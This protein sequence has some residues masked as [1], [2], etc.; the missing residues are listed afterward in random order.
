MSP[1]PAKCPWRRGASPSVSLPKR[2]RNSGPLFSLLSRACAC[3][4]SGAQ[5]LYTTWVVGANPTTVSSDTGMIQMAK[6]NAVSTLKVCLVSH[7]I[8]ITLVG[9]RLPPSNC[10]PFFTFVVDLTGNKGE[11]PH[12]GMTWWRPNTRLS[13]I[14]LALTDWGSSRAWHNLLSG[15]R[16]PRLPKP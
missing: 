7:M 10:V 5:Q 13:R 16:K 14:D 12:H 2:R 15:E 1:Q 6:K 8:T 4:H 11:L 9:A 3:K